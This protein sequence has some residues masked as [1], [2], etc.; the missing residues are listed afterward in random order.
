MQKAAPAVFK[1]EDKKATQSSAKNRQIPNR[2]ERAAS[3]HKKSIAPQ[4]SGTK[5]IPA[6]TRQKTANPTGM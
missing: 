2:K 5:H 1:I 4:G 6:A 3:L